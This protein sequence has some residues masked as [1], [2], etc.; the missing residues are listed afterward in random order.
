MA[1][2]VLLNKNGKTGFSGDVVFEYGAAKVNGINEEKVLVIG[3]Q[4]DLLVKDGVKI[5]INAEKGNAD[6]IALL[7]AVIADLSDE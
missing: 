2:R 3:K 4:L 1:N 7:T 6:L 5:S